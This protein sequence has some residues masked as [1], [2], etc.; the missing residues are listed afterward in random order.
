MCPLAPKAGK[1]GLFATFCRSSELNRP[2]FL[3]R[4]TPRNSR[5]PT[6]SSGKLPETPTKVSTGTKASQGVAGTWDV[7]AGPEVRPDDLLT[8]G[9]PRFTPKTRPRNGSQTRRHPSSTRR[10][11]TLLIPCPLASTR[12]PCSTSCCYT[13]LAPISRFTQQQ[14]L[15]N[16]NKHAK[17][18]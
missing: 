13:F 1:N 3:L 9:G 12:A 17:G 14:Q 8:L 7:A 16:V 18:L 2:P 15:S 6:F 5:H 4:E 11:T 10:G